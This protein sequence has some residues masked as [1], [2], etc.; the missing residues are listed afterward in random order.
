VI[1]LTVQ[2][3]TATGINIL[4]GLGANQK[5]ADATVGTGEESPGS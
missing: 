4:S 5:E 1:K 2:V 3:E